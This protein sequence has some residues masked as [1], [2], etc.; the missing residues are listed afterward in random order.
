MI[1]D[2]E[3]VLKSPLLFSPEDFEFFIMFNLNRQLN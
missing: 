3:I 2:K 1:Y